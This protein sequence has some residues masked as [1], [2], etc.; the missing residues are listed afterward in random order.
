[1]LFL[2]F[3][4]KE[5]EELAAREI[6]AFFIFEKTPDVVKFVKKSFPLGSRGTFYFRPRNE[7]TIGEQLECPAL[8]G[9]TTEENCRFALPPV[10]YN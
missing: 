5:R 2:S 3:K 1:L 4:V 10:K 9:A 8:E 7:L 6:N